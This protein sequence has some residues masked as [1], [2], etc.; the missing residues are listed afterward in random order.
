MGKDAVAKK[1][2]N[3]NKTEKHKVPAVVRQ[4][5]AFGGPQADNLWEPSYGVSAMTEAAE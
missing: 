1:E 3:N 2:R 5:A 4:A